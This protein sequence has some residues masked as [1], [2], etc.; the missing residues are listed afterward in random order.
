MMMT[1]R[2]DPVFDGSGGWI[3]LI[4]GLGFGLLLR[5]CMVD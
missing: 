2:P 5:L 4:R 3:G 1:I